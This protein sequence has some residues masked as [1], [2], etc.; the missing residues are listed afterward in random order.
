ML[1]SGRAVFLDAAA[2]ANTCRTHQGRHQRAG[3]RLREREKPGQGRRGRK[4]AV[5]TYCDG[6]FCPLSQE[7]A[8]RVR[9]DGIEN[10]RCSKRLGALDQREAAG[11]RRPQ[12]LAV[13]L[14][15]ALP[16]PAPVLRLVLGGVFIFASVD[17]LLHPADF[18]EII[19]PTASCRRSWSPYG[20]R[21]PML[22]L[23]LGALLVANRWADGALLLAD[24]LLVVFWSALAFNYARGLSVHCGC[25][26]TKAVAESDMGWYLIRDGGFVSWA[27]RP[28]T[29]TCAGRND[30]PRRP[31]AA[32]GPGRLSRAGRAMRAYPI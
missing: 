16:H 22:E 5:I 11:D 20:H 29:S 31:R 26:S 27:W 4:Q 19:R 25:F 3:G 13:R 21:L 17:K 10:V 8:D 32:R 18:A 28:C 23:M 6:M 15:H 1:L 9:A 30:G 7:L 12:P 2:S 14:A 24:L